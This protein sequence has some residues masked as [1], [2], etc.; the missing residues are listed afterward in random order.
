MLSRCVN[1]ER[2]Q[3]TII[4]FFFICWLCLGSFFFV[5]MD[6]VFISALS[7][8]IFFVFFSVFYF[9]R[10]P[11]QIYYLVNVNCIMFYVHKMLWNIL[12]QKSDNGKWQIVKRL[13]SRELKCVSFKETQRRENVWNRSVGLKSIVK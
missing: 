1:T 5:S 9:L 2:Q 10:C 7:T 11:F 8:T 4:C 13:C 3:T 12:R 6:F